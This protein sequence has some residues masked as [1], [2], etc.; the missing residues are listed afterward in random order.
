M[1]VRLPPGAPHAT[2]LF[3]NGVATKLGL[4]FNEKTNFPGALLHGQVVFDG[5]N[6][7]RFLIESEW[8]DDMILEEM[9]KSLILV[10]KRTKC[11]E[12]HDILSINGDH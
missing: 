7:Q 2:N 9:G 1:W 6:G 11:M 4:D 5:C 8:S 3:C 12:I 10:G